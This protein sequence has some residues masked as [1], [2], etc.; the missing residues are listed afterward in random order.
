MG[1]LSRAVVVLGLVL[2]GTGV[3]ADDPAQAAGPPCTDSW[4]TFPMSPNV[5]QPGQRVYVPVDVRRFS[6]SDQ[7]AVVTDLDVGVV[8]TP[9]FPSGSGVGFTVKLQSTRAQQFILGYDG[10]QPVDRIDLQLDDEAASTRPANASYGTWRPDAPL[11]AFDGDRLAS[12]WVFEVHNTGASG[13]AVRELRLT[14]TTND[15]DP[16]S[17]GVSN[18]TDNCPAA[19]N[20]DQ[21]DWDGDGVGNACDA[22]PGVDPN[23]PVPTPT[24]TPTPAPPTTP[25]TPTSATPPGATGQ[26]G[27]PGAP[28]C[29]SS[30]AYA[31]TVALRHVVRT[32]RLVG[33]VTSVASG[34]RTE[35]AVV[36]WRERR[37]EDRA[38]RTVRSSKAGA[39]RT[40][41]PKRAGR[42]YATVASAGTICA[43]AASATVRV[44][45]RH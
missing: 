4:A 13:F 16:D 38:V 21:T 5:V 6:T 1:M 44:R 20:Q 40:R 18:V 37:G 26:P 14:A 17:D 41:A 34:C 15:C 12:Q 29:T 32:H 2:T 9:A 11:S 36:L 19:P 39:F 22:T 43:D 7:P 24:P 28:A 10:N 33:R 35:V 23:A 8:F 30:C 25:T 42:Y 31:R 45:R 3:V 27:Q